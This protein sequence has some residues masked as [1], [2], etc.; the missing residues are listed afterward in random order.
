MIKRSQFIS[1]VARNSE[2]RKDDIAVILKDI[3]KTLIQELAKGETIRLF[4]GIIFH[5][6]TRE[7]YDLYL[8]KQDEV[9][10]IPTTKI[11]KVRFTKSIRELVNN[12]DENELDNLQN[13][14]E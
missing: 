8:K 4:N 9:V 11:P 10:T 13:E 12:F 2:Y 7:A 5:V 1:K 3:E 14:K 6:I